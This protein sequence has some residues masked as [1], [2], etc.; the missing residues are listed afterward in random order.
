MSSQLK[1]ALGVPCKV[2]EWWRVELWVLGVIKVGYICS[3]W[4]RKW[5]YQDTETTVYVLKF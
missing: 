2:L 3:N 5:Y 4:V 1:L